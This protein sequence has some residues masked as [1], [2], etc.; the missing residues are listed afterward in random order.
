MGM[1]QAEVA[2]V[3]FSANPI[4]GDHREVLINAS[5][6]LGESVV[7]GQVT[8]DNVVA[9]KDDGKTIVLA[10]ELN[11]DDRD[12]LQILEDERTLK[13]RKAAIDNRIKAAIGDASYGVLPNG[14]TFSYKANKNN[15]RTLRAPKAEEPTR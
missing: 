7:S 10:P 2:G 6:G 14:R 1:S 13:G 5:W 11:D 12:R 9:A 15:V 4:T 8:P 3:A